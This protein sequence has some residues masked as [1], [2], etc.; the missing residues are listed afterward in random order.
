MA[1]PPNPGHIKV[2]GLPGA[3]H[4]LGDRIAKANF[5]FSCQTH[6]HVLAD[7]T[8][9]QLG[10]QFSVYANAV[11]RAL[12]LMGVLMRVRGSSCGVTS[13]RLQT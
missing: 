12:V 13:N 5:G 9:A 4:S 3:I 6:A 1:T 7:K 8:M 10:E 11:Q 2:S